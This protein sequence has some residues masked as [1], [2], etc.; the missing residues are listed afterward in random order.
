M[1]SKSVVTIKEYGRINIRLK[2]LM[3]SKHITRNYLAKA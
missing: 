1:E 3:D 2:E